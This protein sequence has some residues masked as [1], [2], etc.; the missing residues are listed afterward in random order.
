MVDSLGLSG[1]DCVLAVVPMFHAN[2][3][4]LPYSAPMTGAKLVFPGRAWATRR[5]SRS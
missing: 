3:W 1:Q 4:G 2:A 5:R